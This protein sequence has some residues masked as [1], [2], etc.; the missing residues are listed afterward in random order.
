MASERPG[1]L[2]LEPALQLTHRVRAP[3][4]SVNDAQLAKSQLDRSG[5]DPK[6]CEVV[7]TDLD[8]LS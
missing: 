4:A 3:A 7:E 5:A 8:S 1:R 2:T 6:D